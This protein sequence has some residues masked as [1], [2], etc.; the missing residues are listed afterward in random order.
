MTTA[1][2]APEPDWLAGELVPSFR[3]PPDRWAATDPFH[4]EAAMREERVRVGAGRLAHAILLELAD[5]DARIAAELDDPGDPGEEAW[6][7]VLP[8]RLAGLFMA[9]PQWLA[10]L[11]PIA[12]ERSVWVAQPASVRWLARRYR[13][14]VR[15]VLGVSSRRGD[16]R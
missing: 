13:G 4:Y 2:P 3:F 1:A 10:E 15:G 9:L 16:R 8:E 11:H 12:S 7:D 6:G 5:A 14:E